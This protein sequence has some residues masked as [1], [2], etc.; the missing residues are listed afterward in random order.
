MLLLAKHCLLISPSQVLLLPVL[1]L[2][3]LLPAS[4]AQHTLPPKLWPAQR[5]LN[6]TFAIADS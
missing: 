1:L 3:L 6:I 5:F 2:L 4:A